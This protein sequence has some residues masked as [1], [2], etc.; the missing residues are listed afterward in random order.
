MRKVQELHFYMDNNSIVKGFSSGDINSDPDYTY[1]DTLKHIEN[2]L[3]NAKSNKLICRT[4]I[5][6]FLSFDYAEELY[7]HKGN[8]IYKLSQFDKLSI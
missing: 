4:T 5:P 2:P 3:H 1:E 6:T 8:D 7:L